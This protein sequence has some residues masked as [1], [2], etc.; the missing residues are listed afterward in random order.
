MNLETISA[1]ISE[2]LVS[3]AEQTG[4]VLGSLAAALLILVVGLYLSRLHILYLFY[5]RLR[6][7]F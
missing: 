1:N 4:R 6:S 3:L 5:Y 7:Q 2:H